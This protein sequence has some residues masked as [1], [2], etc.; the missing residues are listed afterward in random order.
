MS[1]GFPEMFGARKRIS[2]QAARKIA[3]GT[4]H[5]NHSRDRFCF[6]GSPNCHSQP[7]D[8]YTSTTD[9]RPAECIT[10]VFAMHFNVLVLSIQLAVFQGAVLSAQ[11][12][13]RWQFIRPCVDD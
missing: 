11:N 1:L 6:H 4:M 2:L 13:S 12:T 5:T 3:D 8:K 9:Y 10:V 7:G